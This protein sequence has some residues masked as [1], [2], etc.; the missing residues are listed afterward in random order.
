MTP[1]LRITAPSASLTLGLG[2]LTLVALGCQ[3]EQLGRMGDDTPLSDRASDLQGLPLRPVWRRQPRPT[4]HTTSRGQERAGAAY[5][6]AGN[7]LYI[8]STDGWFG[9]LRATD[10]ATIWETHITGGV[11]GHAVL[12]RGRVYVGTDA[13]NLVALNAYTGK[14][15]WAYRVQGAITQPPVFDHSTVFFVDGSNAVYALSASSGAWKWQHRR[16]APARFSVAGESGVTVADGRVHLGFSDG[17][18]LTLSADDGAVLWSRDLAEKGVEFRDVDATPVLIGGTLFS[19]SLAG[20]LYAL[21][22][23]TGIPRWR[24]TMTNVVALQRFDGDLI[25]SR[26][27]GEIHRIDPTTGATKWR[28]AIGGKAG[29]PGHIVPLGSALT[30]AVPRGGLYVLDGATGRPRGRFRPGSGIE[31]RPT[32]GADGRLFIMSEAGILYAFAPDERWI[33]VGPT[34][35]LSASPGRGLR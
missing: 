30:F 20:G 15:E 16:E 6:R 17:T 11:R 1:V 21:D 32:T 34:H 14:Q 24:R 10:G 33:R 28:T 13:G 23:A 12:H 31:G 2:L 7:R 19:A 26:A 25:A 35:P 5:D 9:C 4:S 29:P 3:S 18:L 27:T 22:P 8:G